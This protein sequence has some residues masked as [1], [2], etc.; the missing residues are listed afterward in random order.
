MT[1]VKCPGC[2][3]TLLYSTA[4]PFRPFCSQRCRLIDL[5]AWAGETH[6][7]PGERIDPDHIDQYKDKH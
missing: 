2:G 4:N 1:T 7:I 6:Q 5:G 3:K